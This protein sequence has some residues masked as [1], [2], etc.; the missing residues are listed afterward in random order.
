MN[1]HYRKLARRYTLVLK[2]YLR[3]AQEAVLH[4]AYELGRQAIAHGLGVLDIAKM[5][6]EA[7][8]TLRLSACPSSPRDCAFATAETFFMEAL[9][10]CEATHRGFREANLKL[11][12]LNEAL[13]HHT[14]ELAA[15]NRNLAG[16]ILE[17][18]KTEAALRQS[19]EHYRVLFN[20]ARL[21]EEDLRHLSSKIL[22]VQEEE[23]K[24][25]SRELHDQVGQS[26]TVINVNLAVLKK[27]V[28]SDR[29]PPAGELTLRIADTEQLLQEAMET[30]HRFSR[31]LRPAMLDDLGLIPALRSCL[32]IFSER[33]GL[34]VRL[35]AEVGVEALND[36]AKTVLY[37]VAQ[38]SMTNTAK[39]AQ[40]TE[41]TITVQKLKSGVRLEI[42]DNGQGFEMNQE[43]AVKRKKRLGLFGMQERARLV[44]GDFSVSSLPGRGTTVRVRV[45]F[46][47]EASQD[48]SPPGRL[49]AREP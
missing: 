47:G 38:E 40:A 46:N 37:R 44:R 9:V 1:K 6:Q 25:I 3:Q 10:P 19:E 8:R 12:Q 22:H 34:R 49:A 43:F 5:H 27:A 16:E 17:R 15:M 33:T 20:Q 32:K 13:E 35:R 2:N 39:H 48:A 4:Q 18:R 42:K 41:V 30:V 29:Q 14:T 45:P 24:R 36:E 7:L 31:E 21:M 23:R 28:A 26:L 11:R